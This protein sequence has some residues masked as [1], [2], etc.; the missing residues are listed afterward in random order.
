MFY[1][2]SFVRFSV[3]DIPDFANI[4]LCHIHYFHVS[5]P[6]NCI[7]TSEC[8]H[9]TQQMMST[10]TFKTQTENSKFVNAL[11]IPPD[12][13]SQGVACDDGFTL[14][15]LA[16]YWDGWRYECYSWPVHIASFNTPKVM[17][18]QRISS[19]AID[20]ITWSMRTFN[21]QVLFDKH[22]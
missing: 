18:F 14:N 2:A 16:M 9:D 21:T 4:S 13:L 22:V 12:S 15:I 6:L 5:Q 7:A 17:I 20:V 8:V 19:A 11:V 3:R 1:D 10:V